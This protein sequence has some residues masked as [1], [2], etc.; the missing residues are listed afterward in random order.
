MDD[1]YDFLSNDVLILKDQVNKTYAAWQKAT[2]D[3]EAAERRL[4]REFQRR[5]SQQ[6]G[7][8]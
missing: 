5:A 7:E 2:H 8:T 4:S 6:E 3:L 1:E